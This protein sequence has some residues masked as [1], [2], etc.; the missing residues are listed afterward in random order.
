[1]ILPNP[2]TFVRALCRSL[3]WKWRG[4]DLLTTEEEQESRWTHCLPCPDR[5][6]QQCARCTCF[7][8]PK[9][10]LTSE[11]CP[12]NKWGRIFRRSPTV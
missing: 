3:W 11:E 7:L 5:V 9:I 8:D 10:M 1:M 2:I 6:G 12:R 4:Y